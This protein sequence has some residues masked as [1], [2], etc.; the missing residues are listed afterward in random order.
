MQ[1]E[2]WVSEMDQLIAHTKDAAKQ[3][4]TFYSGLR[5]G[6]VPRGDAA[7]VT[8]AYVASLIAANTGSTEDADG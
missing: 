1:P 8:G 6:G 5:S 3:A 4:A 2:N 7:Q